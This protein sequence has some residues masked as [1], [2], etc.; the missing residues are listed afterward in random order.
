MATA[1]SSGV[2][3]SAFGGSDWGVGTSSTAVAPAASATTFARL[4][5][6]TTGDYAMT[7]D[8]AGY[9]TVGVVAQQV[10]IAL[11]TRKGSI[12][13]DPAFGLEMPDKIT[14]SFSSDVD[15]A[16]RSATSHITRLQILEIV[17]DLDDTLPH[18]VQ[19]TVR[20]RDTVT[21]IEDSVTTP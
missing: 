16:V 8:G 18:R 20:F 4:V 9:E 2:G 13:Q 6:P 12:P 11:T 15:G 7:D 10:A 5:D 14:D 17:T 19:V 21:G 3:A 1:S